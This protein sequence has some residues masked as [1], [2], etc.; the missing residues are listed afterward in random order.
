M[1]KLALLVNPHVRDF[2]LYDEWMHPTGLYFLISLLRHNGWDIEY[3]NC[4]ERD[5]VKKPKR[6]NTGDFPNRVIDK[7]EVYKTINRN[8]KEYGIT[9]NELRNRLEKIRKPDVIFI[10]TAMTYW[11]DG[12]VSTYGTIRSVFPK[13]IVI[14]GGISASL[15]PEILQ[16]K[17]PGSLIFQGRLSEKLKRIDV[18]KEI[19]F[20][21]WEPS[22][23]DAFP[24]VK[25]HFHGP[26]LT[27]LGCPL[28]CTYCASSF[29]QPQI[30]VRPLSIVINEM[31]YLIENHDI[32][33]FSFYDDALLFQPEK[34]FLPLCE[35]IE[36]LGK[37]IKLHLPNGVHL[38]WINDKVLN[39]MAKCGFVTL[40]FGYESGNEKYEKDTNAKADRKLVREKIN[41]IKSYGFTGKQIGVYVMCGLPG[42]KAEDVFD[43][44]SFISSL[45]IRVKPVFLS[46]VPQTPLFLKYSRQ[47]PE[48]ISN[49]LLHNDLFFTTLL[50]GWD[51]SIIEEIKDT[52]REYN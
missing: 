31:K 13:I 45:D 12:V 41:L 30:Q 44:L 32:K 23:T 7:P 1:T 33:N 9:G 16:K 6:F 36:S 29:L 19:S 20:E 42:Q 48:L 50:D 17:M 10:T 27:S 39:A 26:V 15:I 28:D 49:P 18:L 3:I 14:I 34:N 43:E 51:C 21:N 24:F 40:R 35:K 2:K 38:Q 22:F 8:Y 46:P 37:T 5:P 25:N 4:L 52:A 11:T 47:I